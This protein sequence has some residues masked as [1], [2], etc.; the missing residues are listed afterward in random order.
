[1]YN[2]AMSRN[3]N[4]RF[5]FL[6]RS[7]KSIKAN[8][9]GEDDLTPILALIV[10]S[11]DSSS[12]EER[13]VL[14]FAALERLLKVLAEDKADFLTI[15]SRAEC[16]KLKS[17][18]ARAIDETPGSYDPEEVKGK[19]GELRRRAFRSVL[20]GVLARLRISPQFQSPLDGI[21]TRDIVKS[22]NDFMHG[23]RVVDP[24]TLYNHG[25]VLRG[26]VEALALRALGW[27]QIDACWNTPY[28]D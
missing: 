2:M 18:L 26:I 25:S 13:F 9:N 5:D 17:A 16:R 28:A 15:R 1:M 3:G 23:N 6:K 14:L 10:G 7:Y 19:L 22:R 8:S 20:D 21:S 24:I 11:H 4:L 27:E 12:S